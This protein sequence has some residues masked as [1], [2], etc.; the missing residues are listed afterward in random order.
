M[1]LSSKDRK[2]LWGRAANVCSFPQCRQ[3]LTVDQVDATTSETFPTVVGEEAHIRSRRV[4]GPR[5]DAKYPKN[6]LDTYENS[7]LMCAVHHTMIDAE[8]GRGF[9][10]E[11]L[12]DMRRDHEQQEHRRERISL[13][14]RA[15]IGDQY[16]ADDKVL[17]DQ[18]ELRPSVDAI[19]VDVPFGCRRGTTPSDLLTR[20]AT[21][22]P[23]DIGATDESVVT[24]AA[25]A[26]LHPEWSYNALIVGGPGQGKSTLLQYVCQFHRARR[27]GRNAYTGERQQLTPLTEITRVPIRLDFRRYVAWACANSKPVKPKGSKTATPLD[28]WPSLAEYIVAQVQLR[29]GGHTFTIQDLALLISTE[30]V[31]LAMDGLDEVANLK[32]RARVAEEIIATEARLRP[33][34]RNLVILVATRPGATT[35]TLWSSQ[36]FPVLNLRRLTPGLRLQYLQRWCAAARLSEEAADRLQRTFL[37]NQHVP[38]IH[39]LASY[40]MQL[41]ILLHLLHRR[42]LLP[43]QRTELYREYLKAFLDREQTEDKEPLLQEAR[44]VIEDIHAYLG[45]HL[46]T[47]AEDGRGMG[48]ITRVDLEKLLHAQLAGREEGQKFAKRLFSAVSTRVLCLVERESG[49][50]FEVQPLR[51]YFAALYIFENAPPKGQGN[52][53]DDCLNAL[54]QRPYWSNVCRFFV[55]MF[56]DVEVRGIRHS[57][58]SLGTKS[59]LKEHPLLRSTA[60]LLLDD[61]TFQGQRDSPIQEIVD[62]I[63]DGPGVILAED[64]LLD[65]SGSPLALSNGAGRAQ[66]VQHLKERLQNEDS[67][68]CRGA[69]TRTL[70]RHTDSVDDVPGWWWS[71]FDATVSWLQTAADLG[72]LARMASQEPNLVKILEYAKSGSQWYTEILIMGGYDGDSDEVLA[73]CKAEINDGAADVIDGPSSVTPLGRLLESALIAQIRSNYNRSPANEAGGSTLRTRRRRAKS[74]TLVAEVVSATRQLG[75]RPDASMG[76]QEWRKRLEQIAQCWGD[77]WVLRQAISSIP[78]NLDVAVLMKSG[79]TTASTLDI[80]L[81][82]EAHARANKG[83]SS[84]WRDWRSSSTSEL[85]QRHWIFSALTTAH[86]KVIVELAPDLNAAVDSLEPKHVNVIASG[87]KAFVSSSRPQLLA[88]HEALR[89][90]EVD[91]SPRILWLLRIV[92]T[93]AGVE[94]IDKRLSLE[95]A[96]LLQS[97]MGDMRELVRIAGSNRTIKVDTFHGTRSILPSGGWAS[98]IKLG[99]MRPTQAEVILSRPHEWPSDIVQ[100][101]VEVVAL[102]IAN[103]ESISSLAETNN[104]FQ[105]ID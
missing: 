55:G 39:E 78:F 99:V 36:D 75:K 41:A 44:K 93:G 6:K 72:M 18:A 65:V 3:P 23:G 30:P 83:N 33:D 8:G 76:S 68:L 62:F 40:P 34:A 4:N 66:V 28:R 19:F 67:A 96:A 9:S 79:T 12:I 21:E 7:I 97:G 2:V 73:I 82:A 38:H 101:A 57:L 91:Y 15:Y 29:S 42:Q 81:Q 71:Q 22:H 95:F 58:R 16:S 104:W 51:E 10:V 48:A 26:L 90:N 85:H 92:T 102:R 87:L 13:A 49:F 103:F 63:L 35:S 80:L 64:G 61:R 56:S 98:D 60:T 88:V 84:W 46:Q 5:Y 45:W 70:R 31:L 52:A 24:G 43:Q 27:L 59:P 1:T 25:Q 74:Q 14:I 32:H 94:Q 53:R 69:M 17:F 100:R 77:G 89:R 47:R 11:A 54:L 50:E 105:E 20:I 86:T 37:D